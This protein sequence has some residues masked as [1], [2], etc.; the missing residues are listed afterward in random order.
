MSLI[1][2]SSPPPQTPFA[3]S[4][5]IPLYE[6]NFV[7]PRFMGMLAQYV[8]ELEQDFITKEQLLSEV[9]KSVLDP[10][11]YTQQWK[12]HNLVG[13][14][15]LEND[16]TDFK[17]FPPKAI[18]EQLFNTIRMHYLQFLEDLKYNRRKVYI[19]VWANILRDG[20]FISPHN[21]SQSSNGYLAGTLYVTTSNANFVLDKEGSKLKIAPEPGRIVF[22]PSCLTHYTETH[23]GVGQRISIS[24]DIVLEDIAAAHIYRP[25]RLLDDP[26]TMPGLYE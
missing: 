2:F 24:F 7:D 22:F 12:Q 4:F 17:R 13:D 18:Q 8:R 5:N 6:G 16:P 21:H 15:V 23:K 14:T 10:L 11:E 1:Y 20:E 3:P 25:H 26:D 19:N 9:P